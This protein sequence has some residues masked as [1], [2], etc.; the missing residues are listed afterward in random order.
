MQ[1]QTTETQF[2]YWTHQVQAAI[3]TGLPYY[4]RE[5]ASAGPVGVA[6]IS[7]TF[8]AALWTLNF[9]CYAASLGIASVQMHMTDNS[10]ASPWQPIPL[11]S[12]A[13][14]VR[15]S[16]YGFAA[17]AQIVGSGNGTTQIA[18]L[19]LSGIS[20][21]YAPYVRAYSVYTNGALSGVVVINGMTSNSSES[22]KESLTVSVSFPNSQGKT[23]YLSSLTAA[24]ADA[25]D[26]ATWNGIS[27]SDS[28]G[29]PS[30]SGSVQTVQIGDDGS[31]TFSVRDS[32]AIVANVDYVLGSHPVVLPSS[33]GARTT[34][35][36]AAVTATGGA[37]TAVIT[38]GITSAISLATSVGSAKATSAAS[39]GLHAGVMGPR[40]SSRLGSSLMLGVMMFTALV[41]GVFGLW[42]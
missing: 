35:K 20:S 14:Y 36:S 38:G 18:A 41:L 5:M 6:G 33:P 26:G 7:D 24:G 8:G 30:T 34:R 22:N 29:T 23:L 21:S 16:Y 28:D 25:L 40:G 31:A 12:Q 17:M 39:P 1:L 4:L 3:A 27:Y 19:P 9:F 42:N 2:D 37:T 32:E 13:P 15:P 10:Y 11:D